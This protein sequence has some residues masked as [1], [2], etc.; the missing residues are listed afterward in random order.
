MQ[1]TIT[2]NTLRRHAERVRRGASEALAALDWLEVEG[3]LPMGINI[4]SER[5]PVIFITLSSKCA[6]LKDKHNAYVHSRQPGLVIWRANI[7]G[8]RVEW[9]EGG[10]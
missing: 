9:T 2:D 7:L 4:Q 3:F 1:A 8:C 10:N 6:W 5:R